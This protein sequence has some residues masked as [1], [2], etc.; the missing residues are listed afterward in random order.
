MK[1]S[2]SGKLRDF[3][4]QKRRPHSDIPPF[5]RTHTL[6]VHP[7]THTATANTRISGDYWGH[8]HRESLL[9]MHRHFIQAA[10]RMFGLI[11]G[12]AREGESEL[13][14]RMLSENCIS[15]RRQ[16]QLQQQQQQQQRRRRRR[17]AAVTAT[18]TAAIRKPKE[19]YKI[20]I[21][22]C[23]RSFISFIFMCVLCGTLAAAAARRTLGCVGAQ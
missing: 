6:A 20:C 14:S 13:A 10:S 9:E 8:R 7:H 16:P 18:A 5:A 2:G 4:T 15:A 22:L 12:R 17:R 3:H 23:L 1:S 21:I 19:K 11:G